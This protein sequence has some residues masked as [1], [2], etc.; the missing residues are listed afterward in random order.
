MQ[1]RILKR[2]EPESWKTHERGQK[3]MSVEGF[4]RIQNYENN[5]LTEYTHIR[6]NF[7]G[8]RSLVIEYCT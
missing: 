8:I 2:R 7:S 1:N 4:I 6:T 5:L 3:L